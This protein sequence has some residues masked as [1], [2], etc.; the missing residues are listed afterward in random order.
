MQEQDVI[1][2]AIII[3]ITIGIINSLSYII[4]VAETE[5]D[6]DVRNLMVACRPGP[7]HV[8]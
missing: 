6:K 5:N 8:F 3:I 1:I 7:L 4:I 2:I